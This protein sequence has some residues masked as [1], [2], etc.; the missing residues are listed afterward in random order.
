MRNRLVYVSTCLLC[1]LLLASVAWAGKWAAADFPLRVHIFQFNAHSRYFNGVLERTDGEGRANL[2][3]N[4]EPSGFDFSYQCGVRLMTSLGFET[5]MARWKKPGRELQILLPVLGGKPGQMDSCDLN[6]T[7]KN[8]TAY[9]R[10]NGLLGEEPSEQFKAW[11]VKHGYDPE[12]GKDQPVNL[13][14]PAAQPATG[15]AP[16]Q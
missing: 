8:G 4:S 7:M 6:V 1:G 10:H 5:Y 9:Y 14:A 15:A 16:A 11:M 2:Y 12:H 13:P 3:E